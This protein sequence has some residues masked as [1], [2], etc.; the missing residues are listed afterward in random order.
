M[1]ENL[2]V[3]FSIPRT[4]GSVSRHGEGYLGT[5]SPGE[6][7]LHNGLGCHGPEYEEIAL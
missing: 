3:L 4:G 5:K 1:G 6:G 7:A 2:E